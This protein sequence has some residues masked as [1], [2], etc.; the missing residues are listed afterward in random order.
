MTENEYTELAALLFPDITE[1]P[2]QCEQRFPK[3]QLKEGAR[4]TRYAPSP[5]GFMHIGNLFSAF[6]SERVAHTTGGVFYVRIED[7]DKKREVEGGVSGILRDLAAFGCTVDEGVISET[8]EKG[9]Y[10]PYRQ[11][12]RREIYHVFAKSLVEKG[13]AYPCFCSA[14][15]LDEV[16]KQ[17]EAEK[18]TTGYYGEY[19]RCRGLCFDEIKE[20]I[21]AGKP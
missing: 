9:E 21:K 11:S 8:E 18:K 20:N 2:E 7:T 15:T 3:R 10:G 6:I 5:T 12:N 16:R 4:V 13:F 19:A 17:Q 1:T 14:E